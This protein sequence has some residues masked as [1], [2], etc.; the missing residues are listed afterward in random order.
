MVWLLTYN[1]NIVP[2]QAFPPVRLDSYNQAS[3][4]INMASNWTSR[5][6]EPEPQDLATSQRDPPSPTDHPTTEQ[7]PP[8][9]EVQSP[10]SSKGTKV[11]TGPQLGFSPQPEISSVGSAKPPLPSGHRGSFAQAAL[12]AQQAE[13]VPSGPVSLT[14]QQL[15]EQLKMKQSKRLVPLMAR[16][17]TPSDTGAGGG[18]TTGGGDKHHQAPGKVSKGLLISAPRLVGGAAGKQAMAAMVAAHAMQQQ[19]QQ[20]SGEGP[21]CEPHQLRVGV[22]SVLPNGTMMFTKPKRASVAP[23]VDKPLTQEVSEA[24]ALKSPSLSPSVSPPP[25]PPVFSGS[26]EDSV[27]FEGHAVGSS[28]QSEDENHLEGPSDKKPLEDEISPQPPAPLDETPPVYLLDEALWGASSGWPSMPLEDS[29]SLQGSAVG[30]DEP[31]LAFARPCH[32]P[33]PSSRYSGCGSAVSGGTAGGYP[34]SSTLYDSVGASPWGSRLQSPAYYRTATPTHPFSNPGRPEDLERGA[35]AFAVAEAAEEEDMAELA[36]FLPLDLL[37]PVPALPDQLQH[38]QPGSPWTHM[39]SAFADSFP[40]IDHHDGPMAGPQA[41]EHDNYTYPLSHGWNST[42]GGMSGER[43]AGA[44]SMHVEARLETMAIGAAPQPKLMQGV[45]L[46]RE[47]ELQ[48][49]G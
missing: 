27:C 14:D 39:A 8:P 40:A 20:A 3:L 42:L 2:S 16:R 17:D 11:A 1:I 7:H 49:L 12:L 26:P 32:C 21:A 44:A 23:S 5:L 36:S 31:Y 10:T 29:Y 6:V 43:V 38:Q 4:S 25:L 48:C 47:G 24:V 18:K 34:L 22:A 28:N 15:R 37:G 13:A 41:Q 45:F 9:V 46:L 30:G 35:E 33:Q 19:Q